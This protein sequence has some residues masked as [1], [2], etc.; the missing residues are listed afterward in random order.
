MLTS[1][2]VER[3]GV[4]VM[5]MVMEEGNRPLSSLRGLRAEYRQKGWHRGWRGEACAQS[6]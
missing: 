6:P 1:V 4:M 5:V 3:A 2:S